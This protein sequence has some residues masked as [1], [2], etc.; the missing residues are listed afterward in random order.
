MGVFWI[1][2]KIEENRYFS[3]AFHLKTTQDLKSQ[4]MTH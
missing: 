3:E 4:K 2:D 1:F